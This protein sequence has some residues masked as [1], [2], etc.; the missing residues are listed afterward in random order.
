M[1]FELGLG[2]GVGE[3]RQNWRQR[4]QLKVYFQVQVKD[5]SGLVKSWSNRACEKW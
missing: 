5:D 3:R 2:A 4:D 1:D